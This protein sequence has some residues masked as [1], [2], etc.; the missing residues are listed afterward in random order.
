MAAM[1]AMPAM[2]A[3]STVTASVPAMSASVEPSTVAM[4]STVALCD[5]G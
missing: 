4:T 1:A 2:S 3:M 5:G